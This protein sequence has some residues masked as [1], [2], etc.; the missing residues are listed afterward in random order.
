MKG[1]D[2]TPPAL[3]DLIAVQGGLIGYAFGLLTSWNQSMSE[4]P[5]AKNWFCLRLPHDELPSK[6]QILILD[7]ANTQCCYIGQALTSKDTPS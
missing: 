5:H 1:G 3:G 4:F 7:G 6:S 2:S